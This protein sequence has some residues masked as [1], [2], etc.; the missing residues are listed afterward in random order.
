MFS[1]ITQTSIVS[2]LFSSTSS[3]VIIISLFTHSLP[4]NKNHFLMII[5]NQQTLTSTYFI[6]FL[7]IIRR[8]QNN[9]FIPAKTVY[10]SDCI[11]GGEINDLQPRHA[12]APGDSHE[13]VH[14]LYI[15]VQIHVI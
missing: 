9:T 14:T 13:T 4:F 1:N 3:S 10:Q 5:F 11:C 2:C 6:N 12:P 7:C 8:N 15:G